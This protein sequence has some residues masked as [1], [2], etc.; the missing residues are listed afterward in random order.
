MAEGD[1]PW[2][3]EARRNPDTGRVAVR[4]PKGHKPGWWWIE[5]YQTVTDEVS[6]LQV[7]SVGDDEIA[8]WIPLVE[9]P[10]HDG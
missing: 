2:R 1:D 4:L 9:D 3:T 6:M 10:S 7:R 5:I 8:G